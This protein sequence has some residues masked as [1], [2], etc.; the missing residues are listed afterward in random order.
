[1]A[2]FNKVFLMGNLTRDPE[3]RQLASGQAVCTLR[4]A[5]SRPY[6]TASG[7]NREDTL[8]VDVVAWGRQA[9]TS[10]TYLRKGSSIFVEG[11]LR[12]EQWQDKT[13][14][15]SRQ[16]HSV[17]AERVQFLN[18]SK[19]DGASPQGDVQ[20]SYQQAASVPSMD[21]QT[22]VYMAPTAAPT[23]SAIQP[24]APITVDQ[25]QAMN[26][27]PAAVSTQAPQVMQAE[28]PPAPVFDV[29]DVEDDIPF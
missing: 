24:S 1:M 16:R 4:M 7:E 12:L 15:Q 22:P 6:R 8:F 3:L 14:G 19:S 27:A 26:T 20:A 11:S 21:V 13:T 17:T 28:I 18:T 10:N 9:E 29:D 5:V 25:G 23:S 2:S